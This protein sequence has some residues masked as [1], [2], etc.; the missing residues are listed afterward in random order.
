MSVSIARRAL[1][2]GRFTE[3]QNPDVRPP[4]SLNETSFIE[5][6]SRC[7]ACLQ[8]CDSGLLV[9]GDGGYPVADF[10]R[11]ACTFCGA[12][13]VACETGAISSPENA[14]TPWELTAVVSASCLSAKGVTCRVCGDRCE[15]RAIRFQLALGGVA[16][17][18]IDSSAC[19]GC[20]ACVAPC[21]TD[22]ITIEHIHQEASQ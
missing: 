5:L 10:E 13:S 20:G 14:R 17:P 22:A 2:R 12:C 7:D 15:A 6:C 11:G 4:W 8:A 3:P 18:V 16:D 19:T 1:L 21:P 9:R